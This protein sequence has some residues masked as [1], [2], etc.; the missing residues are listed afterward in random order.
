MT[1]IHRLR[2]F[3]VATTQIIDRGQD[4][5]ATLTDIR[6]LL[7]DLVA[8]D[9]W[10]P[11]EYAAADPQFYRQ[12]LLHADPLER[13]SIVSFVW[14]PGQKTPVHDHRVWGLVGLL[15]GAE[16][17]IDYRRAPDGKLTATPPRLLERGAVAAVSPRIGDIHEISNARPDGVSISI[18]VYGGNIGAVRRATFDPMNGVEKAFISGYSNRTTPNLWDRSQDVGN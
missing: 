2:D 8:Y 4:E 16:R 10:L 1:S 14:G 7:G 18:H 9:D 11:E 6:P 15:R 17:A 12:Y 3:V 5:A 13:L